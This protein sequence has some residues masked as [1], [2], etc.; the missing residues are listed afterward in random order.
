MYNS[1]IKP[2]KGQCI[3]CPPDS[4]SYLTANRCQHHYW[5]HRASL[6]PVKIKDIGKPIPK[7]SAKQLENLKKYRKVRDEFMK[8]KLCEAKLNGCTGKATDL[9][10]AKGKVGELLTDKRYFK[11]LCRSCHSYIEVHPEFA[12]ENGYSLNRL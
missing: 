4:E 2:K 8:N 6:K 7:V 5:T 11:A 10:H 1:T 9:H 3:D 12:K